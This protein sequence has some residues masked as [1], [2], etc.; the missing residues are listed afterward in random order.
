MPTLLQEIDLGGKDTGALKPYTI[1][2]VIGDQVDS[3][4]SQ[5]PNPLLLVPYE[6]VPSTSL[7]Y[8]ILVS[9]SKSRLMETLL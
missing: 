9:F 5:R 1:V 8:Q 6:Q 2:G 7:Y 3:A 4:V